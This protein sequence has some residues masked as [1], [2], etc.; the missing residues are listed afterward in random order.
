MDFL[1]NNKKSCW[2]SLEL[3]ANFLEFFNSSASAKFLEFF[4]K[5]AW[6]GRKSVDLDPF[7]VDKGLSWFILILSK[8]KK[9]T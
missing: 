5:L 4:P 3:S 1:G 8:G 9:L 7:T 2:Q 6:V